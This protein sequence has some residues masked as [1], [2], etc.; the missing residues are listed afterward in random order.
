[1][2]QNVDANDLAEV[3]TPDQFGKCLHRLRRHSGL[4]LRDLHR[5]GRNGPGLSRTSLSEFEAGTR[6]PPKTTLE[7]LLKVCKITDQGDIDHWWE[8]RERAAEGIFTPTRGGII[9]ASQFFQEEDS[10]NEIRRLILT[11][12][13][14]VWLW[15]ATLSAHIPGLVDYF[16][17]AL[18]NGTKIKILL[19]KPS[20]ETGP[21]TSLTMSAFRANKSAEALNRRL[22]YN[23]NLL[24]P[25][26][27]QKGFELRVVDYLGPYTLYAYDPDSPHG[28]MD[29]RLSSFRG[30]HELRPTFRI[31]HEHDPDWFDYFLDQFLQ[32]WNAGERVTPGS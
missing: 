21:S 6:L 1:M 5:E 27:E 20:D 10:E 16:E 22:Q 15:G 30:K 24:E 19:I 26:S 25:L 7:S 3:R 4:S 28:K 23:L 14:E 11:A 13:E 2:T 12:Q 9:R 18:E 29:L 8:A 17:R 31:E 32:T